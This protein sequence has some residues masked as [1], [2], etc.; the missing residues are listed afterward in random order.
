MPIGAAAEFNRRVFVS[1][2][3]MRSILSDGFALDPLGRAPGITAS[4]YKLTD[5]EHQG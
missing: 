5:G 2:R 1:A 4:R 3:E